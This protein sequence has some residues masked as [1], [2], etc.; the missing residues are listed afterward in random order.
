M[1][2][3]SRSGIRDAGKAGLP[4]LI[5]FGN[6]AP[7][8]IPVGAQLRAIRLH[9]PESGILNLN[10]LRI[11][12]IAPG[13]LPPH[14][15]EMSSSLSPDA[16]PGQLLQGRA[17][18]TQHQDLPWWRVVFEQPC[19][20][21]SMTIVNRGD[22]FASRAY[23]LC[24]DW[25]RADGAWLGVDNLSAPM[26]RGRLHAYAARLEAAARSAIHGAMFA[27]LRRHLARM[28]AAIDA[29]DTGPGDLARA[30]EATLAAVGEILERADSA[31]LRALAGI[32][33][34]L[35]GMIWRGAE[36]PVLPSPSEM[37]MAAFCLAATISEHGTCDLKRLF[38]L[39]RLL[40]TA[41]SLIALES[42]VDGFVRRLEDQGR[43]IPVRILPHG[44]RRSDWAAAEH[45]YV[46]SVREVIALLAGHGHA[47][48]LGYGTLLG[49]VREGRLIAHDDDVDIL[50]EM[51]SRN[52]AELDVE[53]AALVARLQADG[54]N[55]S[56]TPGFQFLKVTAPRAGRLVDVF[57]VLAPDPETV[58][59]YLRNMEF[60]DLPRE[61]MLPFG[62]LPFYGAS[63]PVPL[64]PA[65]FL[66]RHF[67]PTWRIPNRFSRFH[68]ISPPTV[69]S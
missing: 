58:R 44:M 55:A 46:A 5:H 69:P 8:R 67:G 21:E 29:A 11:D 20:V 31:T 45:A 43:P 28:A 51:R 61:S 49:A 50:A 7:W 9:L 17:V 54:I 39:Q 65:H 52:A 53:L 15:A 40:P 25:E 23:G 26:A 27:P 60:A 30:R 41:E 1:I 63:I 34:L 37:P 16:K 2:A 6:R 35:D 12:G 13:A 47:G 64:D 10:A 48:A 18:H 56:I 33:D 36:A 24:V 62:T 4:A 57:P 59:L 19:H 68:W 38:E 32:A 3:L 42:A 22:M 14:R 66:E